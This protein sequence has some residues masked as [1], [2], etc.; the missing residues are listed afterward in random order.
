DEEL[1]V[2]HFREQ[3]RLERRA[4][5]DE[6]DGFGVLHGREKGFA[7]KPLRMERDVRDLLHRRPVDGLAE[8]IF[9]VVEDDDARA[10]GRPP[11]TTALTSFALPSFQH[12]S[13][14]V[15]AFAAP[16]TGSASV[17]NFASRSLSLMGRSREPM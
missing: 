10:H 14:A 15:D 9:V 4:V 7:A 12:A 17:W 5:A 11:S 13:I 3:L 16:I 2:R 1:E 8:R 6:H